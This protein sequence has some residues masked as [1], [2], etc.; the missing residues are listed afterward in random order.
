[1]RWRAAGEERLQID[2]AVKDLRRVLRESSD[3]SKAEVLGKVISRIV[4]FFRQDPQARGNRSRSILEK[5]VVTDVRGDE[6][7]LVTNAK[8]CR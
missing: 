7:E 5:M 3:R 6:P 4:R 2:A 1:M 8:N